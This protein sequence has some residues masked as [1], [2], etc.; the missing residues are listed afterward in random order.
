M[1]IVIA[2]DTFKDS[3]TAQEVCQT[4]KNGM[5]RVIPATDF[6]LLPIA[7]GGEGT[8]TALNHVQSG[9][10]HSVNIQNALNETIKSHFLQ[11]TDGSC[12]VE[13]A[14]ACGLE[15]IPL[16]K[17]DP[18]VTTSFGVGQLIR[19][20]LEL[21]DKK[22]IVA[23][24]GTGTNDGGCGLLAAL[25]AVFYDRQGRAFIPTGGTLNYIAKLDIDQ[26]DTR[27]STCE[28]IFAADV[29]N[30]LCGEHGATYMFAKQKGAS[31]ED[32]AMMDSGLAHVAKL[33]ANISNNEV[34]KM[35]GSGAA[36]GMAI[37]LVTL[38]DAKIISGIDVVLDLLHFEQ[39]LSGASIVIT[40]EGCVDNQTQHGKAAVG[41]AKR[42]K[43]FN[44]QLP[45]LLFCG[46]K[47]EGYQTVYQ[48]GVDAVY[49]ITPDNMSLSVALLKA[50]KNLTVLSEKVARM[51]R[52]KSNKQDASC[53]F[54]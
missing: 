38:F 54:L 24:G 36:G 17:R 23:L 27:L 46:A 14:K 10:M 34:E 8:I 53:R 22:I 51:I 26:L 4:I 45:V 40:G 18:K 33:L 6:Y 16:D 30:P 2:C 1:K 32:L 21:T 41:V 47:K 42:A 3:M 7:D 19:A 37:G 12:V 52:M 28:I 11:L 13:A 15:N 49:C 50:V 29:T 25:G 5:S 9:M 44:Q 43:N 20:A 39:I 35:Q 48:Q 31:H